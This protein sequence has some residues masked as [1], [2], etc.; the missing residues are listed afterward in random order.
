MNPVWG[1]RTELPLINWAKS[2]RTE[3][4]P[5]SRGW[6]YTNILVLEF[7]DVLWRWQTTNIITHQS[8]CNFPF[9][10]MLL[11]NSIAITNSIYSH[12]LVYTLSNALN[13]DW[14]GWF[15][16]IFASSSFFSPLFLIYIFSLWNLPF[17]NDSWLS[18][19]QYTVH[20]DSEN[21]VDDDLKPTHDANSEKGFLKYSGTWMMH[22][23]C[24]VLFI[25]KWNKL[26]FTTVQIRIFNNFVCLQM[27]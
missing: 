15:F 24:H 5:I 12:P 13:Y 16:F 1:H 23:E 26:N 6:T 22:S 20:V 4:Q 7:F 27:C 19:N 8:I 2:Q 21:I 3:L 9:S 18:A 14:W 25:N 11:C 17:R 10:E